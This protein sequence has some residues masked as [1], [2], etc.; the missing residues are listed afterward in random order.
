MTIFLPS[1]NVAADVSQ[2]FVLRGA[3]AKVISRPDIGTLNPGGAFSVSGG[4]RTFARGNPD[5]KPIEAYTY[6]LSAEWYFAPESALIVGLFTRTSRASSRRP[7]SR[8][9]SASWACPTQFFRRVFLPSDLFTVT[10]PVN[11]EGGGLKG[12]EVGLQRRSVFC[13][14][15]STISV[16]RPTTTFV[17]SK[18]D[19]PLTSAAGAAV[20]EED[21]I[22]L[23]RH[24]ANGTLYYEDKNS[25]P[26]F[27]YPIEATS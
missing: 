18:V 24:T 2:D 3:I 10:Q 14:H 7:R 26:A 17:D 11:S 4:N 6:D 8:F 20:V 12:I 21:L 19:Y 23:S 15:R 9:R 13:R 27:R 1:L 25:A 22:N 5:I 16:F